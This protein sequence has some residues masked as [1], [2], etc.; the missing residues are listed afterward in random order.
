MKFPKKTEIL[1]P[2]QS[3]NMLKA[4]SKIVAR[5]SSNPVTKLAPPVNDTD[6]VAS[7][8]KKLSAFPE[9]RLSH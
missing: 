8:N 7:I 2:P 1:F 4:T 9:F 5:E 6:P 3:A